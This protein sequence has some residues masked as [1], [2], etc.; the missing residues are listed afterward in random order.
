[1]AETSTKMSTE[2]GSEVLRTSAPLSKKVLENIDK[3]LKH[4]EVS[5]EGK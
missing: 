4:M 1:M 2:N 5:R 3:I